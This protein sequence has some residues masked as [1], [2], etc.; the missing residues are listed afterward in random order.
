M[1]SKPYVETFIINKLEC[2]GHIQ[3]YLG[4]H[5]RT[6][7]QTY[8]GKKLSDTKGILG[9]GRLTDRAINFLQNYFE[10]AIRQNSDVPSM[11]KAISAVLF[12]CSECE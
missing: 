8:R 5:L 1:Q 11:K 12:H 2:I 9:K 3:K 6:L 4:C 10:I 7:R